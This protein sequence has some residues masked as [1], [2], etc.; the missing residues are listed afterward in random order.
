ML[1]CRRCD[2]DRGPAVAR[3]GVKSISDDDPIWDLLDQW[4]HK[5]G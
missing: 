2:C 4:D 3:F 5:T 1:Q